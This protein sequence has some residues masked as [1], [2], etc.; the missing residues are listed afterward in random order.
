[1][2]RRHRPRLLDLYCGAGGAATG[3]ARA[4]FEVIGVD[5]APM[6]R[7]PFEF[8]QAEALVIL[9]GLIAGKPISPYGHPL[10]YLEDFDAI[11]ASPPCQRF[12]T[13]SNIRPG[14]K[15]SYPDLI[16]PTRFLL[17]RSHLPSVIENVEYAP[18]NNAV[19]LCG[20]Q[21]GLTTDWPGHGT[22]YLKRHR[23]FEP[24]GFRL[25]E[26][27]AHDH[28][29]YQA[30]TVAGHGNP[31]QFENQKGP[32]YLAAARRLM[33]IDWMRRDELNEAV[34]PAYALYVGSWLRRHLALN[35][36]IDVYA[37]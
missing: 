21:F 19:I 3:Y 24:I 10:I 20:S 28:N 37:S 4:G 8:I 22:F 17:R 36:L 27:G 31:C 9:K 18:L 29:T 14:L 5:I 25:P 23:Q 15:Q 35:G 7:Y 32:G 11:H 16:E 1:M 30:L 33:Q 2:S 12:S 26:P 13:I 6:P 34:P